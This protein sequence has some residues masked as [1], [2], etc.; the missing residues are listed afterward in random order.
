MIDASSWYWWLRLNCVLEL[1]TKWTN[2]VIVAKVF[3]ALAHAKSSERIGETRALPCPSC[4]DVS[5]SV[6]K[7]IPRL[8]C[9]YVSE[10]KVKAMPRLS[11]ADV[12]ESE[13]KAMQCLSCADVSESE[14]KALPYQNSA[15]SSKQV[16][17][18]RLRL[19]VS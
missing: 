16:G 19:V 6:A 5:G 3:Y 17:R 15:L 12:S 9:A 4:A 7:A 14:A 10:S 8:S 2:G 13:A 18:P 1:R 11:C